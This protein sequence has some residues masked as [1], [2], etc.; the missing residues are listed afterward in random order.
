MMAAC[1]LS[2]CVS[3]RSGGKPTAAFQKFTAYLDTLGY[4][5][6]TNRTKSLGDV[7]DAT[8]FHSAE[9]SFFVS[10]PSDHLILRNQKNWGLNVPVDY[11]SFENASVVSSYHYFSKDKEALMREDG[12]IEEW[13][14]PTADEAKKAFQEFN[15]IKGQVYFNTDSFSFQSKNHLYIFHT[16][17]A[18]FNETLERFYEALQTRI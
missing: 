14:F 5:S 3:N 8:V 15:K 12:V 17:A 1:L 6:D 13:Q 11:T 18:V 2:S 7:K 16:R 4:S 10:H 9:A